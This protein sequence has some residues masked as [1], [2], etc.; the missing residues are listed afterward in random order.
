MWCHWI[1]HLSQVGTEAGRLAR[2][3]LHKYELLL[4]DVLDDGEPLNITVANTPAPPPMIRN[5]RQ[6]FNIQRK[7]VGSEDSLENAIHMNET[8][9][10]TRVF[11]R[12]APQTF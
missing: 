3:Q 11:G 9:E 6:I 10:E 1:H 5:F 2:K 7:E 12:Y 8:F 4:K